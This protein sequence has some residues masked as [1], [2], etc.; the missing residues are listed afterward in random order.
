MNKLDI[1]LENCYGIGRL[2][3]LF[4]FIKSNSYLIYAPNG[5]M[6]SSFARTF[7][8]ISKNDKKNPCDRIYETRKTVFTVKVD[9]SPIKPETILVVDAEDNTFDGSKK[10]SNFIASKELKNKYDSIYLELDEK[11]SEFIKKLK[12]ISQSTDCEVEFIETFVTDHRGFYESLE[13]IISLLDNR[14]SKYNFRYNDVFDKK[15]NVKKF[16]DKNQSV[17]NLYVTKYEDLI[18]KSKFFKNQKTL[19]ALIKQMK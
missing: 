11:K 2:E 4:D 7:S 19:L 1:K 17:L 14:I 6:K 9:G 13:S 5:T 15:G 8:D 12:S 18:S 16:L 10:I 3:H